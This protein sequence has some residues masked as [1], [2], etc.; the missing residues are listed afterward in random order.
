MAD[1]S[2]QGLNLTFYGL[3]N[4]M[5]LCAAVTLVLILTGAAGVDL[6]VFAAIIVVLLGFCLPASS[7]VARWVEKKPHTFSVGAASFLGIVIGPWLVLLM[8]MASTRLLGIYL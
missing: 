1:G 3:F 5:A 4:A 8:D 7:L 6:R 2:W